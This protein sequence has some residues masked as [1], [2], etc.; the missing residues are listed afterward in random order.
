MQKAVLRS[1]T[2]W[3]AFADAIAFALGV[4]VWISVVVLPALFVGRFHT[5]PQLVAGCA[6]LLFLFIGVVRRA[7]ALLLL[8]FPSSLMVPVA[9]SPDMVSNYVYGPTRFAVVCVGV[10]AYLFGVSFFTSFYEPAPPANVRPLASSRRPVAPRW[11]R[12]FRVYRALAVLSLVFPITLLYTVNFDATS[13]KFLRQMFPGRMHQMTT[14]IDLAAI[15]L[16]VMLYLYAFLDIMKHHR[17]GDRIL[18]ADLGRIKDKATRGVLGPVFFVG[19]LGAI[20]FMALLFL[21]R[22]L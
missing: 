1:S 3:R 2:K 10:I 6:P 12:R 4:N 16:W 14:V 5:T 15:A 22:F 7:D 19:L 13:E 21:G 20:G 8:V 17:T 11:K 18:A 9:L